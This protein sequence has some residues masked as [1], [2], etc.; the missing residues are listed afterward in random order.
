MLSC[1]WEENE[2]M[3][4]ILD[5]DGGSIFLWDGHFPTLSFLPGMQRKFSRK[6]VRRLSYDFA[7]ALTL[8]P[9]IKYGESVALLLP[10]FT[11]FIIAYFGIWHCGCL[12]APINIKFSDFE[13]ENILRESGIKH[14]VVLEK[15]YPLVSRIET[16][17]NIIVL[18]ISDA[19]PFVK[20]LGYCLKAQK[21]NSWIDIP[22]TDTRVRDFYDFLKRGQKFF[23]SSCFRVCKQNEALILFT[24][25]TTGTPKGIVHTHES[26]LENTYSCK[27]LF[28]ELTGCEKGEKEVFLAAAPYFH[29]MGLSTMLHLPLLLGADIVMTFPDPDPKKSFGDTLLN[30]ITFTKASVFIGA[31][32]MYEMMLTDYEKSRKWKKF[33]FSS[34]KICISGSDRMPNDIRARFKRT[35]YVDI[36]EGYGMSE[37]GITHCQKKEFNFEDGVGVPLPRVEQK[38]INVDKERIGEVLV[39]S[40]GLMKGYT[41]EDNDEIFIDEDGW[42]H[43][44]DLGEMS[45][46]GELFLTGRKKDLIKID[47]EGIHPAQ[48]EHV[49]HSHYLIK[50]AVVVG[51]S[52]GG[53]ETIVAYVVLRDFLDIKSKEE[54]KAEL[55]QLCRSKLSSIKVPKEINFIGGLPKNIFGKVL[56]KE[57]RDK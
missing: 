42:L 10:N 19:L 49:L 53:K 47:G 15:F 39:R 54:I 13:I 29:I 32:R 57:L 9:G 26:L 8:L 35:F 20:G 1:F 11:E 56:K 27:E 14:A 41:K 4:S 48:I 22:N 51:K 24:S 38:L 55:F 40:K 6:K 34:L 12:A 25:G 43:T 50:E 17:K 31:P 2:S 16:L 37:A 5:R 44:G 46:N 28:S 18:R 7:S 33:D 21:E 52:I 3:C 36:L 45:K 30:A 23:S